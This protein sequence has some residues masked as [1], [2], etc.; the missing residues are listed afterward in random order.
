MEKTKLGISAGILAAAAFLMAAF[1]GYVAMLLMAGYILLCED[2][3]WLKKMVVKALGI[4]LLFSLAGWV[5]TLIPTL[6]NLVDD[7]MNL[8]G[9]H[10][11]PEKMYAGFN[12]LTSI[13]NLLRS[14]LLI[15]LAVVAVLGK[16]WKVPFLDDLIDKLF[17]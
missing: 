13:L 12:L 5:I 17:A 9:K 6:L 10:F 15:Y 14:I 2:S 7:V 4:L 16:T 8:F 11:Y 3:A 1:G